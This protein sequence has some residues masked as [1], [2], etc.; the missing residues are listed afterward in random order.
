[1]DGNVVPASDSNST[2]T[3]WYRVE[4]QIFIHYSPFPLPLRVPYG[5]RAE[6]VRTCDESLDAERPLKDLD[7]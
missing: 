2:P 1:M 3:A 5:Y 6:R 4:V 7:S